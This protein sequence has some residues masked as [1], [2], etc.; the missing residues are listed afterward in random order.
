MAV[1]SSPVQQAALVS[2][3]GTV[4]KTLTSTPIT[5]NTLV[6]FLGSQVGDKAIVI[7]S[8]SQTGVTW[9]QAVRS[10]TNKGSMIWYGVVGASPS[11]SLTAT[12]SGTP[13]ST[14]RGGV[15]EWSGLLSV[16]TLNSTASNSGSSTTPTT[17]TITPTAN[18]QALIIAT[19]SSTG[20]SSAPTNGFTALTTQDASFPGSYLV[21]ANTSGTYNTAWT[22]SSGNWETEIATFL[23]PYAGTFSWYKTATVDHTQCGSTD[24]TSFP[25]TVGRDGT[26]QA[27]DTDLKTVANGGFV[28]SSS[29]YDIRPFSDSALTTPLPYELVFYSATTGALEMHINVP[30]ISHTVDTVIYLGFGNATITTDGTSNTT[31]SSAYKLVWHFKDG[32]TLTTTDSTSNAFNGTNNNTATAGVGQIDGGVVLNSAS[33]QFISFSDGSNA[34]SFADTT[35][36]YNLWF[37]SSTSSNQVPMSKGEP[38]HGYFVRFNDSGAGIASV[39]IKDSGGNAAYQFDFTPS[40]LSDGVMHKLKVV[41]TTSTTVSATNA[42]VTYFDGVLQTGSTSRSGGVYNPPTGELFQVS[43]RNGGSPNFTGTIDEARMKSTGDSADWETTEWNS[44]KSSSTLITWGTKQSTGGGPT[45]N[46]GLLDFF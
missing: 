9:Q 6:L 32:T 23:A 30:T 39:V 17:G 5:G 34:L 7:N 19:G 42:A 16:G 37:K 31:W 14:M 15:S 43:G 27:I 45:V 4:S 36:T 46:K 26:V 18:Q 21:V 2:S 12:L 11:A 41:F 13:V 38:Y 33:S 1:S 44:Q 10:N 20:N 24:S 40:S 28:Q 29:G 3:A 25:L 22:A 35:F 8:I